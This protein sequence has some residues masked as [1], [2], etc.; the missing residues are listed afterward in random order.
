M[1][2]ASNYQ[3]NLEKSLA[4]DVN[5]MEFTRIIR[6]IMKEQIEQIIINR[7]LDDLMSA[8]IEMGGIDNE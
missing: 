1:V 8:K 3:F 7:R 4:Y 6:E 2:S 5:R